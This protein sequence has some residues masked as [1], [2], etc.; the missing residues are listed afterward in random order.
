[1][2]A[3][4]DFRVR[5]ADWHADGDGIAAL[6]TAVFIHEQGVSPELEHDG[7]DPD[8]VHVVAEDGAG[9]VIGTGRL[10]ADGRVG[11]MAVSAGWRGRGIGR[12]LLDALLACA[13]AR[14]L[15]TVELHAQT[16]AIG[17]YERAG[18]IAEGPEFDE[19]GM[20]HRRMR[21]ALTEDSP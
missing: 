9:R 5:V 10:L 18:F 6:R 8:C 7:L 11:R 3:D 12:A 2:S 1:M 13:R 15:A 16:P 4:G 14:G 21:C 20:P 19:A 17:F